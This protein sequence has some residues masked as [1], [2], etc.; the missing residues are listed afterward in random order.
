MTIHKRR[1]QYS[2]LSGTTASSKKHYAAELPYNASV[3]FV[4]IFAIVLSPLATVVLQSILNLHADANDN[5]DDRKQQHRLLQIDEECIVNSTELQSELAIWDAIKI[6]SIISGSVGV[7]CLVLYE[8]FRRDPIVRKYCYDRKRLTQPDRSPPPLMTSRSLWCGYDEDSENDNNNNTKTNARCRVSCC[9]VCPAILELVFLNLSKQYIQYSRAANEARIEREKRGV[10]TCCR[11]DWYH[12]NCCSNY[13]RAHGEEEGYV[14]DEDGYIF[15]PGYVYGYSHIYKPNTLTYSLGNKRKSI[16]ASSSLVV[17]NDNQGNVEVRSPK[18]ILDLFPED[19][20]RQYFASIQ[21]KSNRT[22]L[23]SI[24]TF[25][26]HEIRADSD[27]IESDPEDINVELANEDDIPHSDGDGV[28]KI[29]NASLGSEICVDSQ[30][31]SEERAEIYNLNSCDNNKQGDT[32]D[33]GCST[34]QNQVNSSSVT[35]HNESNTLE[36]SN[37]KIVD[38]DES[39]RNI[40]LGYPYRHKYILL[41]PGFHT[42]EDVTEFL[43]NFF[44]I[45]S[46]SRWCRKLKSQIPMISPKNDAHDSLPSP[47]KELEE[48]EKELLRCAGLDTYLLVRSARFGFD[49]TFYPFLVSFVT[50][51][52]IYKHHDIEAGGSGNAYMNLT[53]EVIPNGSKTMIWIVLFT[54]LLYLYIMRRLWIEWEG[55]T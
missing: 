12:R 53:I 52:P 47:G 3:S 55:K 43:A 28:L 6:T 41:P 5:N 48:G 11:V 35:C 31:E 21:A 19:D 26:P 36:E 42:W 34:Q 10:Y 39:V 44:F 13:R 16:T 54:L 33:E 20:P 49:V 37:A 8:L 51:L 24:M 32:N 7:F 29:A 46:M 45:Q 22:L 17:S 25:D 15:Y 1:G 4:A 40:D 50:V 30:E 14:T 23:N 38:V 9:K 27:S 18:T 2:L